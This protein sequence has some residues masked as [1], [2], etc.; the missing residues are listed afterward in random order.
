MTENERKAA[1]LL[2]KCTFFFASNTKQFVAQMAA[3]AREEMPY[4]L[5][6]RQHQYLMGVL[7]QHRRQ[8]RACFCE[9]CVEEKRLA[10][11]AARLQTTMFALEDGD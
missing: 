9:E 7:H 2:E 1:L 6:E 3:K 11:E 8:H 4:P 5:S 10:Q